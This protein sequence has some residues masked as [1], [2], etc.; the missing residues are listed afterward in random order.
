MRR[1]PLFVLACAA[2]LSACGSAQPHTTT[3]AAYR[4]PAVPPPVPVSR[5]RALA[6]ADALCRGTIPALRPIL[7]STY[8]LDGESLSP[9]DLAARGAQYTAAARQLRAFATHLRASE[10]V[11]VVRS[12]SVGL[13]VLANGMTVLGRSVAEFPALGGNAD[14]PGAQA[15]IAG[16]RAGI[17]PYVEQHGLPDCA[18]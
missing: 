5:V 12:I 4:G 18:P 8:T 10:P 6:A 2:A 13:H 16:D 9:A 7:L 17:I 3:F 11:P 15:A 14:L 1:V